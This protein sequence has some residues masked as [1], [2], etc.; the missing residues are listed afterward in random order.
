MTRTLLALAALVV[1]A[2]AGSGRNMPPPPF[3]PVTPPPSPPAVAVRSLDQILDEL[4]QVRAKKAEI[5]KLE[6]ALI[7]EAQ[8]RLEK[9]GERAR[10][11]GVTPETPTPRPPLDPLVA[12]PKPRQP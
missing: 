8:Q 3:R 11:L 9:H 7:Q 4:E 5:E 10:Q 12:P 6:A 2:A 1:L